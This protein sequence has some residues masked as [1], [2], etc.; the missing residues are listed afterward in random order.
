MFDTA[1]ERSLYML[2]FG[3]DYMEG[4]CEEILDRLSA[5]NHI[6][7]EGYGEDP[8]CES[9]REK[10]RSAC[11]LPEADV[12]FLVGGTQ[13]NQV[14]IDTMLAPYEGVVAADTGHV[15]VHEAGAI[16]HSGH[17]VL[18]VPGDL[19]KIRIDALRETLE[20]FR[21]DANH[22]HMVFPGMVYISHP[23]EYGTL[24]THQELEEISSIC[25]DWS[26]PLYLDGARLSYALAS[27]QTDLSLQ[28]I[29]RLCDV[30][31]IGGTKTGA[32]F[33]EAVVFTKH[34]QPRH[35]LTQ[36]KQHGALL[37]KGFLLGLQ[38]DTL[39]TDD[40]YLKLGRHALE[41]AA[42]LK[43]IIKE[44]GLPVF[45]E[46]PTNQQFIIIETAKLADLAK[47]VSYGFWEPYDDTHTV[48]RLATSWAT[49]DEDIE[50]L[51]K[52]L[53]A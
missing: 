31:Y 30:F 16:E 14:V 22:D 33:G 26:I 10:I 53:M 37:A 38:F 47:Q 1:G 4:A 49:R 19:G 13:T 27:P 46:T 48:I 28:E 3:C 15:A 6:P 50:K 5:S 18:T 44:A 42:K 43:D 8:V 11:A 29:A 34:N 17:K 2:P 24:Y 52:I 23:T 32:L 51:R 25:H 35:F 7:Q 40:L 12:F 9:A 20:L 36:V 41:G 21:K 39:F 45:L